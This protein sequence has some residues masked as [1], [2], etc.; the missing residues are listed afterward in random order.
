MNRPTASPCHACGSA[1]AAAPS[2]GLCPV[3]LLAGVLARGDLEEAAPPL[4]DP[5]LLR[6]CGEYAL[7]GIAGRGGMGVVFRARKTG[8]TREVALKMIA[9]ADL[10]A[11]EEVRRFRQEAEVIA[12]LDHPHIVPVHDVGE[13]DGRPFF[14]MKLAEGGT[15][16]QRL[17]D[18]E[19]RF[20]VR[21]AV[22]MMVKVSRAVQFAHDRGVL[23]RDLKPANI[24]L[25]AGGEPL[26]SDFGLARAVH[27][28]SASSFGAAGIGTPAYM[29]PEQAGGGAALTTATDVHGLGAVM[30]HLLT[31]RPP[32]DGRSAVESLRRAAAED[33][34]NPRALD[35]TIDRDLATICLKC[36]EKA[37]ARR[38]RSAAV[39][40]DDL[41]RWLAG[42][43][44]AAR[45]AGPAERL[46]KWARRRPA[47]AALTFTA[48]AGLAALGVVLAA[49]NVLLRRERNY[50]REQEAAALRGEQ[51]ARE[52]R[53][54]AEAS[55][56]AMRLHVYASDVHLAR[57]AFD[58]GHLG[59]ARL[60]LARHVPGVG[61]TDLRGFEWH[62]LERQCRGHDLAVFGGFEM[63]VLSTAWSPDG[64]LMAVGGRDNLLRIIGV[65]D[66]TEAARLPLIR[67]QSKVA[68]LA[69]LAALPMRS[70]EAAA[71]LAPG[72]GVTIGEIRMRARPSSLGVVAAV[73]WSPDGALVATAGP[74]S[75]VR[76]WK[77]SDWSLQG[78]LPVMNC[79]QVAFSPDGRR[80]VLALS[81][82]AE[83][84]I[85]GEVR[86]YA[87]DTLARLLTVSD[88]QCAFAI[89]TEA[90]WLAAVKADGRLQCFALTDCR[91][92]LETM[93]DAEA[94]ALSLTPDAKRVAVLHR[95]GGALR[96]T[97]GGA[98]LAG[99]EAGG[100]RLRCVAFSPDGALLAAGGTGQAVR[101]FDGRSGSLLGMLRGH[102]DEVLSLAFSPD[103]RRLLTSSNDHTARL[104][105]AADFSR[106]VP[107]I[108]ESGSLAA[109]SPDGS[110]LLAQGEAGDVRC[111]DVSGILRGATPAGMGRLVLGFSPDGSRFA[112]VEPGGRTLSW[113]RPDGT[114][115]GPPVPLEQPGGS[116]WVAVPEAGWVASAGDRGAVVL[117]DWRTGRV[118]RH[119]PAAPLRPSRLAATPDGRMLLAIEWPRFGAFHDVVTGRWQD[120]RALSTGTVGP[121]AFS[122]DSRFMASGGDDNTVTVREVATLAVVA[123]LR[124][125]MA[126]IK[127]LA[128]S[129]D[130][131]TLVSGSVDGSIRL[132]HTPTWRE[133]GPLQRGVL[134]T[135]LRF[136]PQGLLAEA[137]QSRWLLF[138]GA[139]EK[140]AA[141]AKLQA[142]ESSGR[143][144]AE[145]SSA[146]SP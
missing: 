93:V 11:P 22:E 141:G 88:V 69:L 66:G 124:G 99:L 62:A 128:F 127:S 68:D 133:L 126:E 21:E 12:Q 73:A 91:P 8:M 16:A 108:A 134:C 143:T 81:G 78:F 137:F 109:V 120:R 129:G 10:A 104:W 4:Q 40:A 74:G 15:L 112:T 5:G 17:A 48:A 35:A 145:G 60:T 139:G 37:P 18:P 44:V 42:E 2:E 29:A 20:A 58:D 41:E 46:W 115:D 39:L 38:Y 130:G 123:S 43:P 138:E 131:G 92:V 90:G 53:A 34:V 122:A 67:P 135:G 106:G 47:V 72:S 119:L 113:W 110:R 75:Y 3:C 79:E 63:A 23:H 102:D 65:A 54:R 94:H 14:V 117:H 61:Q 31:G 56:Q 125:H 59:A 52:S 19:G 80:L 26:V 9:A 105:N 57:R 45:P 33:P 1:V 83:N 13:H 140:P 84:R 114:A 100:E 101:C 103:G 7:L 71:L 24:L 76:L 132:W 86:V 25:D 55:E 77:T 89:A 6:Q 146:A 50:A 87:A 144:E 51:H 95:F 49:G 32:F 36:L 85:A 96:E 98:M 28:A 30:Y 27:G 70:P 118:M 111:L 107:E 136:V 142:P 116:C 97:A 82:P 64:R 121:V